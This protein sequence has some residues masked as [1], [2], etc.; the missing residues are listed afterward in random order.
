MTELF[1]QLVNSS[2]AACWLVLAVC[3]LRLLLKKAPK[4]IHVLLWGLVAVR[5][6]FP[7]SIESA[8]SLIPSAETIPPQILTE[9]T[10]QV[11]TGIS[12]VNSQVNE[13]LATQY[14]EGVTVPADTGL[15]TMQI[16]TVVWLVG[17]VC[18]VFYSLFTYL[19]LRKKVNTA[20][21]LR[22]N[23]F[24]SEFVDS[25]FVLGLI[26]P[27]IYLPYGLDE[28]AVIPLVIAHEQAHIQRRDHW[29]KPL[30]FLLL[31]VYWF[32]PVL[33]LAYILLCRDIE[34][35]C[36]EKVI[37]DFGSL[38]KADYSQALLACSVKRRQIAACPLAFGEVGV[39]Q[40]VKSV[41]SYKK[42]AFWLILIATLTCL[43]T[44]VCFLTN[45]QENRSFAMD[46]TK[47]SDIDPQKII[48][49]I[50]R[51]ENLDN[52][53]DLYA[54]WD[55]FAFHISSDFEMWHDNT[56]AFNYIKDGKSYAAQ[57]RVF[58]DDKK[59]YYVTESSPFD[60]WEFPG[61][62]QHYLEALKYLPQDEI[63]AFSPGIWEYLIAPCSDGIPSDYDNAILYSQTRVVDSG[64]PAV[65]LK[66]L[67][68][69]ESAD[70][71]TPA[72]KVIHVF[73]A[74]IENYE[75]YEK[76]HPTP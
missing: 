70:E 44:A 46:G 60:V 4:W 15:N 74:P 67:P 10:F 43:V 19:R 56:I 31:C 71:A 5:L 48:S 59:E 57:L 14:Y 13:Y 7:F 41:L 21:K 52:T 39:K 8:L 9:N 51:I 66:I 64:T 6:V 54:S 37:A 3:V 22:E 12:A 72:N 69:V 20:V 16:L 73:Y 32:N 49:E 65:H 47:L 34:C 27:K 53:R 30:G 2:I 40:R 76:I 36:D 23:M 1:L 50:A 55:D 42:P 26:K 38:Q 58:A 75:E 68:L 33:W 63:R 24:Q 61:S 35:A 62:L 18:M 25:P 17:T 29:W 28:E 11:Q 45:P